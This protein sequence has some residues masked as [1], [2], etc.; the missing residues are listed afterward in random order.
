MSYKGKNPRDFKSRSLPSGTKRQPI[1]SIRWDLDDSFLCGN[2][3]RMKRVWNVSDVNEAS[4]R[5][6]KVNVRALKAYLQGLQRCALEDTSVNVKEMVEKLTKP[7][8]P[9][10]EM[11]HAQMAELDDDDLIDAI[12]ADAEPAEIVARVDAIKE[13]SDAV[14]V[15]SAVESE[16]TAQEAASTD[17]DKVDQM[18]LPMALNQRNEFACVRPSTGV[19]AAP[20]VVGRAAAGVGAVIDGPVVGARSGAGAVAQVNSSFNNTKILISDVQGNTISWSSAGTMG[21]KGSRKCT[22]YAAQMAAEE[23]GR[24]A[25][26]H[27]VKTLEVEVHGPGAGRESALRAL[28]AIGFSITSIRDVSPAVADK[29]DFRVGRSSGTKKD[30]G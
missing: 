1:P 19:L 24:K 14:S 25:Y 15:F 7:V 30:V 9:A 3:H 22:P 18:S 12:F 23:A 21:F 26:A 10:S 20:V 13:V 16:E 28:A 8:V 27:G 5:R 11:T 17:T 29:C 4:L 6:T 2:A